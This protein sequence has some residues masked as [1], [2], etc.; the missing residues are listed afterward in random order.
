MCW[1]TVAVQDKNPSKAVLRD[2][3]PKIGDKRSQCRLSNRISARMDRHLPQVVRTALTVVDRRHHDDVP[4][5][6]GLAD[7]PRGGIG[8]V[9]DADRVGTDG[10]VRAVLLDHSHWQD[11][12]RPLTIERINLRPGKLFELVDLRT[13]RSSAALF[14]SDPVPRRR[15]RPDDDQYG[16]HDEGLIH[17]PLLFLRL[18]ATPDRLV[19][20]A[21]STTRRNLPRRHHRRRPTRMNPADRRRPRVIEIGTPPRLPCLVATVGRYRQRPY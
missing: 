3:C 4:I 6:Q 1:S 9:R 21:R 2:L 11:E 16:Q 13:E 20:I 5:G 19:A 15:G 17:T 8:L 12:H 7:A 10:Q 14:D 18:P